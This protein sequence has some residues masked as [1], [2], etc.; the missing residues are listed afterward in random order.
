V[1][2]PQP[3]SEEPA[4]D[5]LISKARANAEGFTETLPNYVVQQFMARYASYTSKPDWKPLDVVAADVVYENKRE[6]YRNLK[7]NGKPVKQG[8]EELSGSWSTGEFG[9]VLR[10]LLAPITAAH[11]RLRRQT[12]MAGR[13]AVIYGY[14]VDREN[15]RWLVKVGSQSVE[16]AYRGAI[17]ID[18]ET[19]LVLRIEMEAVDLPSAFPLDKVE[20]A[21]DYGFVRL[22]GTTEFLLPV[23]AETL[24]CQ[25]GTS[26]CNR[27]QIDFR[28]YHK[29]TGES[30]ITFENQK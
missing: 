22:G 7:I 13:T 25:S 26:N 14:D 3:A 18:K 12:T 29:Y 23:H 9:T 20:T 10:N 28:N 21:T 30:S 27:N 16:P 8:M 24:S 5:P 4:E 15:S 11:F 1:P 6:S 19:A 17:W 2:V